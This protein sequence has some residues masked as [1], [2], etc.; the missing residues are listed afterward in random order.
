MMGLAEWRPLRD[1]MQSDVWLPSI[2]SLN[3]KGGLADLVSIKKPSG[4]AGA[5][6]KRFAIFLGLAVT[7]TP[8]K[9]NRV[10]RATLRSPFVQNLISCGGIF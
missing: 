8:A 3:R 2:V 6:T 7:F 4:S 10:A 1:E 5:R 9:P